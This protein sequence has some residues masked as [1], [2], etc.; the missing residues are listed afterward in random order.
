MISCKDCEFCKV[1]ADG[2]LAFS[3]DPFSNVKEPECINKW[4]LLKIDLMVRSYEATMEY[5]R[6]LAPLQER[7]FK[8][9]ERELD[10]MDESEQWKTADD[11]D[12]QE[13][14]QQNNSDEHNQ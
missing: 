14:Q 10:D 5:S 9:V 3:C 4:L 2:Q 11:D 1:G 6:R 7:M 12:E 13:D 8:H